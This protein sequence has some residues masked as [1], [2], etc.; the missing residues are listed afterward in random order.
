MDELIG[1]FLAETSESLDVIDS[2]L[3]KFE[4]D[5]TDRATLDN[6]FRLLHT[7]KGTCGFLGLTRLE[8]VAHAGETLLGKFRDGDLI[9]D[10]AAVTLVLQSLDRIKE[11]L[12]GLE[13]TGVEPDGEDG[14]LIARLEAMSEGGPTRRPQPRLRRS[15]SRSPNQSRSRCPRLKLKLK[16]KLKPGAVCSTNTWAVSCARVKCPWPSLKPR[17]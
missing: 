1:E 7:I 12:A 17:S 10:S 11:I 14:D 4:E 9:A 5:P 3:V 16:L 15:R 8:A 6:I 13:Q 2:E